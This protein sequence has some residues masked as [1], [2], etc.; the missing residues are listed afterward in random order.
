MQPLESLQENAVYVVNSAD[1][2]CLSGPLDYADM[3]RSRIDAN[4]QL[5]CAANPTLFDGEVYLAPNAYL[6][7]N[8]LCADFRR[9][10]FSTLMYWRRDNAVQRPWHIFAAGVI[11]SRE[12]HLIAAQMAAHNAVAGRIYFPA[13]SIDDHDVVNGYVDYEANMRREVYEETGL[14]L[15][16][17]TAE[18]TFNLVTHNRSVALFKRYYFELSTDELVAKIEQCLQTQ[19][20]AELAAIIPIMKAGILNDLSPP[21]V[22]AFADWH[23]RG[24]A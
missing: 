16:H 15:L 20:A 18:K 21:Y 14:D 17:A 13:G 22:R 9:T 2:E 6:E 23:F 19:S 5:E 8:E 7:G 12:G 11:V 4:W 10:S 24:N 1:V 3:N